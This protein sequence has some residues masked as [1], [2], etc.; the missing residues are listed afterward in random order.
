MIEIPEWLFMAMCVLLCIS[1]V[2]ITVDGVRIYL[3]KNK[4]DKRE[5]ERK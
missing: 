3:L 1:I 2:F 4:L 5:D